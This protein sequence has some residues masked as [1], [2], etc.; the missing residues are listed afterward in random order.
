MRK[1]DICFAFVIQKLQ[2]IAAYD[3]LSHQDNDAVY[4]ELSDQGN[5][6]SLHIE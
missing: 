5:D 3:E 4:D 2:A 1:C 6:S